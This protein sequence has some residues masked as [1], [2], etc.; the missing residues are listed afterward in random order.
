MCLL[1]CRVAISLDSDISTL[2]VVSPRSHETTH[3][4]SHK[5]QLVFFLVSSKAHSKASS[6]AKALAALLQRQQKALTQLLLCLILDQVQLVEARVR[7]RQAVGGAVGLVNLE[8]L[9]SRDTLQR[10]EA[11]QGDLAGAWA[12]Q[13]WVASE[14]TIRYHYVLGM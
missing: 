13:W 14:M 3:Q 10:L 5:Q 12:T 6:K 1:L 4:H 9:R 8:F 2:G 11:L 7:R